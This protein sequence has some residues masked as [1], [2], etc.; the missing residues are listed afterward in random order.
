MIT[1]ML[2]TSRKW[3]WGIAAG[4]LLAVVALY[5]PLGNLICAA[6]LALVLQRQASQAT[7]ENLGVKEAKIRRQSGSL[8]YEALIY[9]PARKPA[10]RAV[11]LV[12][13]LS[14]LG[15]YHPSLV[16]FSRLMANTGFLVITPDIR[17]FRE[18]QIS[19]EPIGQILFWYNQV[20]SLE[21]SQ[22]VRKTGLAGISFSGTLVLMAA[23][24]P[25]IRDKVAFVIGIGPY[26]NL[27]RCTKD[28]FAPGPVT[29]SEG[30][31]PTRFYAKWIVMLAALDMLPAAEDRSFLRPVLSSLLL[32]K[33]VPLPASGLTADGARW[34]RLAT[35]REDQSDP[36]LARQIEEHLVAR[37]YHELDPK[38][39][40]SKLRCRAFFLHGTYDDLIP[41]SESVELHQRITRSYLLVSPFLTHTHPSEKPL[42]LRQKAEA[43]YKTVIFCYQL[44]RVIR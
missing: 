33:Q 3:K 44:A 41:P 15:C 9:H 35:L 39:S 42:T 4:L 6:R 5:H 36:E 31:Y 40:L 14:E 8:S 30:Y 34:Y 22:R 29:V 28:W 26:Y 17:M 7:G 43:V 2:R 12:A 20:G 19:A 23:A 18:F 21:G 16:A 24:R 38:D 13:G 1:R 25:E 27:T 11:I 10:T 32:Q 37:V